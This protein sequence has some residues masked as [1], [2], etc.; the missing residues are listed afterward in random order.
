MDSK[1]KIAVG[2]IL[3][4]VSAAFIVYVSTQ[5]AAPLVTGLL[6]SAAMLVLALGVLLIGTSESEGRPV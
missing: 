2:A 4:L 5:G 3:S 1:A 6:G